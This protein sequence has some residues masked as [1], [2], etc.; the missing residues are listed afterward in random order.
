MPWYRLPKSGEAMWRPGRIRGLEEVP[1]PTVDP[2][3]P[4]VVESGP[5]APETEPPA[6]K[7]KRKRSKT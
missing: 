1:G 7:P 4:A 5:P 3:P 6:G 2:A